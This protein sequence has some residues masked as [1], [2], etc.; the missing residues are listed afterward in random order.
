MRQLFPVVVNHFRTEM[1]VIDDPSLS[2]ELGHLLDQAQ[3]DDIP[4]DKAEDS[5]KRKVDD[6]VSNNNSNN[7]ATITSAPATSPAKK[8]RLSGTKIKE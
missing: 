5:K 7:G 8:G 3:M 2:E 6:D 4:L 1:T